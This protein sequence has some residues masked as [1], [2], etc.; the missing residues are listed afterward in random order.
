M[1]KR[2]NIIINA[3][4][5]VFEEFDFSS[6]AWVRDEILEGSITPTSHVDRFFRSSVEDTIFID[7]FI[8]K[9]A[10]EVCRFGINLRKA[11]DRIKHEGTI[12]PLD[13]VGASSGK[14][15]KSSG[16]G[17]HISKTRYVRHEIEELE[18][19]KKLLH[20]C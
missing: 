19:V 8:S 1:S 11:E 14:S 6:C 3:E 13:E 18:S 16:T 10:K 17:L 9:N 12:V 7:R 20:I 4:L 5:N 2:P 15:S